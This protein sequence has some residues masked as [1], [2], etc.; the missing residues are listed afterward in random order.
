MEYHKVFF[1]PFINCVPA[2]AFHSSRWYHLVAVPSFV[3][4]LF[5]RDQKQTE[6]TIG[7]AI[8]FLRYLFTLYDIPYPAF[9]EMAMR[10]GATS[11]LVESEFKA[12]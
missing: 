5:Q 10:A 3:L 11:H 12:S 1:P 7:K 4:F 9:G 6:K 8:I 2:H